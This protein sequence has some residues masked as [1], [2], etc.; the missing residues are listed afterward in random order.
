MDTT[1]LEAGM[2]KYPDYMVQQFAK[3]GEYEAYITVLEEKIRKL[4]DEL[5]KP[6][7]ISFRN[8]LAGFIRGDTGP[9][10]EVQAQA[11]SMRLFIY[12]CRKMQGRLTDGW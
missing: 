3:A 11:R 12:L 2:D 8:D 7:P 1:K 6:R 9:G 5:D 4:L 10:H